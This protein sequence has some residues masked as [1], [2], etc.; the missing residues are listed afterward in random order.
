MSQLCTHAPGLGTENNAELRGALSTSHTAR[1]MSGSSHGEHPR[2]PSVGLGGAWP[3]PEPPGAAELRRKPGGS[4]SRSGSCGDLCRTGHPAPRFDVISGRAN[5]GLPP[6]Q[7][8]A[9][10]APPTR[11]KFGNGKSQRPRQ[12]QGGGLVRQ[13]QPGGHAG[14]THTRVHAGT[15]A[16]SRAQRGLANKTAV[17]APLGTPQSILWGVPTAAASPWVWGSSGCCRV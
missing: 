12:E 8:L 4:G 16:S 3:D 15:S 5:L 14:D 13:S 1:E 6:L 11:A 9:P 7:P 2:G 10:P 17:G